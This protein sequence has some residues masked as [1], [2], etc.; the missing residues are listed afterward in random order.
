[1]CMRDKLFI[2]IAYFQIFYQKLKLLAPVSAILDIKSHNYY[3]SDPNFNLMPNQI[4]N[5]FAQNDNK[6]K[7]A[8][9]KINNKKVLYEAKAFIDKLNL[10]DVILY[11][12]NNMYLFHLYFS[13]II[14]I[15][16]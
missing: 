12:E 3:N 4:T 16:S 5:N 9:Q 11:M 15:N 8:K 14:I 1:M 6:Q 7:A 10:V 13:Q 2:E